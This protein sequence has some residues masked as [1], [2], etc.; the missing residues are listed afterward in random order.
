MKT[1]RRTFFAWMGIT[2]LAA[3]AAADAKMAEVAGIWSVDGL[4]DVSLGLGNGIGLP[5]ETGSA[6]TYEKR[7]AGAHDYIKM[8]GIPA[9]QET[10]MRDRSRYVSNL[11]P[12]I[13]CKRSW[14]MS[15]KIT[16]QRERNYE[17]E[18]QRLKTTGWQFRQRD[19]LKKLLGF[20]WPL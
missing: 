3:K 11:D 4:G 8:F 19:A 6:M 9:V 13:A 16:A 5:M 12:D 2:P 10:E 18:V 15:V 1:S 20:E 14:S 7:L 17:R